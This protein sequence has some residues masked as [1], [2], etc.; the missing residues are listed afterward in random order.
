MDGV[1]LRWSCNRKRVL[2]HTTNFI[3][4]IYQ[5]PIPL[6]LFEN[7]QGYLWGDIQSWKK[8]LDIVQQLPSNVFT[9]LTDVSTYRSYSNILNTEDCLYCS[10]C[11]EKTL[12]FALSFYKSVCEECYVY[13]NNENIQ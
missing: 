1:Y 10:K 7:L 13:I 2:M 9:Q 12:W 4:S 5:L 11:G 8:K 3:T 6:E